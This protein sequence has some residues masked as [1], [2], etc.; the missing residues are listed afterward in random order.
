MTK[1]D[2]LHQLLDGLF[3]KAMHDDDYSYSPRAIRIDMAGWTLLLN[4]RAAFED[5][6]FDRFS[7]P[8]KFAWRGL[9]RI[10]VHSPIEPTL[11]EVKEESIAF[12]CKML[13]IEARQAGEHGR[14]KYYDA[15]QDE[16]DEVNA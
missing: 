15:T 1:S 9:Q 4:S 2:K 12:E 11:K 3:R 8:D 6:S 13:C 16:L 10:M 5:G 7:H 14:R